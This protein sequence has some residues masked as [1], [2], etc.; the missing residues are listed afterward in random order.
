MAGE[1]QALVLVSNFDD[2]LKVGQ[3]NPNLAAMCRRN[4]GD[5]FATY[6]DRRDGSLVKALVY[7]P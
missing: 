3:I 2:E 7:P 5:R 4:L 6:F 1:A